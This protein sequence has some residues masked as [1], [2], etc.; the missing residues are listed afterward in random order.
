M[1][2]LCLT[3]VSNCFRGGPIQ[4]RHRGDDWPAAGKLLEAVLEVCQPLLPPGES[5]NEERSYRGCHHEAASGADLDFS[6]LQFMVVVSFATFNPPVYGS[7]IFPPWANMVGWCLAMSSMSMVPLYAIYKLCVL[8]GK[9]CNVSS[10]AAVGFFNQVLM[11]CGVISA[12]SPFLLKQRLAYA[13]TPETEHHLVDNGE[14][15]Q[16]TVR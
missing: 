15:R 3:R 5:K 11:K 16:F 1:I 6:L 4:R 9:F 12:N 7:Y 10:S 14:V 13:I 8:P 2:L